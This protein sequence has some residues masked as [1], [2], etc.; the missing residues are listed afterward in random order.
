LPSGA[1]APVLPDGSFGTAK[2]VPLTKLIANLLSRRAE[3]SLLF[4]PLSAWPFQ[5]LAKH[6]L[7]F[8]RLDRLRDSRSTE[9][10]P[11]LNN[12]RF[13]RKLKS[14][15]IVVRVSF[16]LDFDGAWHCL[17]PR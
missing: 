12:E 6:Q 3:A 9:E 13:N 8:H 16:D 10:I 14:F 4:P 15:F 7:Q 1:K 2:A 17:C 11:D 5:L